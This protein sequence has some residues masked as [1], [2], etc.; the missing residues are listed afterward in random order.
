M[1][2][3]GIF[4]STTA[5]TNEEY[6]KVLKGRNIRM[7]IMSGAGLLVM[8]A[9]LAAEKNG[10]AALPDYILGVY[11]G[12]GTGIAI[13]GVLL[14][15]RNLILMRNEDKLKQ[16]RVENSDERLKEIGNCA[17]RASVQVMLLGG[18]GAALIGG[19]YEPI[20]VKALLFMLD[21]FI[22]SYAAAFAYFK[23]KL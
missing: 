16:N 2:F 8:A 12:A 19:I 17:T 10:N 7:I 23:R 13:A 21:L 22:L 6:K 11:C 1:N 4:C 20:L 9:A 3:K 18:T 15:I 5:A 14:L